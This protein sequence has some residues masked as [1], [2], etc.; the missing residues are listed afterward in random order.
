M[1]ILCYSVRLQ[2]L[3]SISDKCYLA[4][5]FDGSKDLIPKSQVYGQDYDVSKSDAYW[6]S[7]WIL[8]KKSI[9]YSVKKAA[10][11]DKITGK[12]LPTISYH[13]HKPT[14]IHKEPQHEKTLFK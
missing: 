5:A 6:I 14:K 1:K 11:F 8:S 13:K 7:D 3:T 9:Q 12:K 10:W 4:T 2:S